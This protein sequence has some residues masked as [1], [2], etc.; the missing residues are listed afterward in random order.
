MAPYHR[1]TSI[2]IQAA[3]RAG[4]PPP[5]LTGELMRK[6]DGAAFAYGAFVTLVLHIGVAAA[7]FVMNEIDKSHVDKSREEPITTIEAGLVMKK[8]VQAGKK[9]SLPVKDIA[10]VVKPPDAPKIAKNPDV[11]PPKPEEKKP[12]KKPEYVP[13][14][15]TQSKAIMD[16]YRHATSTGE[17]QGGSTEEKNQA[18][19]DNGSDY[20]T[21]DQARGDPY[22]AELG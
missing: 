12:E 17:T 10:P 8:K 1:K 14:D 9:T 6:R 5:E 2:G 22:E 20:G 16:K 4:L 21:L 13:P 3:G 15:A 18:G 7:I 19:A 11:V